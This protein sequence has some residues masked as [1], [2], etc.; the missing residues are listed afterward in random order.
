LGRQ[1]NTVTRIF[2]ITPRA[3]WEAAREQ[4]S[5]RPAS[6]ESEGFIHFSQA[7][8]VVQVANSF[9]A[10]IIDLVLLEADTALLRADLRWEPPVGIPTPAEGLAGDLFPHLYGPLDLDA[11]VAAHDFP[12][13][14]DGLFSLPATLATKTDD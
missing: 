5:Y 14:P 4:G 6:L 11:V 12:P 9:Y 2:H 13:G 7:H 8:Q 10:G 1:E 3:A